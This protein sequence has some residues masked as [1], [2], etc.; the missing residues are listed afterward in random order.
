MTSILEKDTELRFPHAMLI[1]ASAGSG[2]TH[3]LAR[4]C[5]QFLLSERV[6]DNDLSGLLAVTFTNNAAKEMKARILAWL[7]DLALDRDPGR[8][9]DTLAL[10][11]LGRGEIRSRAAAL[12]ERITTD[13][14]DFHVQTIDSFLARIMAASADELRLPFRAEITMAYDSLIEAALYSMFSR[15]GSPDL[16]AETVDRFLAVLPKTGSYP[17]DPAERV[18][19]NFASFLA[20]EGGTAGVLAVPEGDAESAVKAAFSDVLASCAALAKRFGGG[21]VRPGPAAAIASGSV[22]DFLSEYNFKYGIFNG[23]KRKSFP[24]GW[25]RD[26]EVLNAQVVALTELNAAAYYRPYV[27]IYGRFKTE[28]ER[29]KRGKT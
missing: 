20:R 25:E 4:R 23:V 7:K 27:G 1:S 8:M 22:T 18:R 16:P 5:V 29:V 9:E 15:I 11:S 2:K 13:Y 14:S 17:W 19:E 28:L 24:A 12:V 3:T 10:V 21:L 6:P 26:L